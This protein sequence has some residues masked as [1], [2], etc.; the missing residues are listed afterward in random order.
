MTCTNRCTEIY[1]PLRR[2]LIPMALF[3][4]YDYDMANILSLV[5]GIVYYTANGTPP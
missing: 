1:M 3:K 5:G 2:P 4:N